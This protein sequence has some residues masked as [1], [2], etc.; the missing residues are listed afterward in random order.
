MM[1]TPYL[2]EN[3]AL[4]F[5]IN[6][7]VGSKY[8]GH[9]A[10]NLGFSG[11]FY[12]SFEEGKGIAVFINSE[13]SDILKEIINSVIEVYDW[14]GFNKKEKIETVVLPDSFREMYIGEYEATDETGKKLK[15]EIYVKN[16]TYFYITN[17][18]ERNMY[19]TSATE[20]VNNESPSKKTFKLDTHGNVVGL[21]NRNMQKQIMF[22]KMSTKI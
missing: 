14:K 5:F 9:E 7:N 1:L 17:N 15:I 3:S 11:I 2:N 6:D 10:G 20:F 16:S 22:K 8:F 4:G 18:Q 13:N 12:G 21:M 19:F